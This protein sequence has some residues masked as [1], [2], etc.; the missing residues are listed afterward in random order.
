MAEVWRSSGR[1]LL[2]RTSAGLVVTDDFLRAFLLRPELAPVEESCAAERRLHERLFERPKDPV[3]SD[4]VARLAD[5]DACENWQA[6]LAFRSRLLAQPS[7]AAA[8]LDLV[9]RGM[10]GIPPLFLDQLVHV[11]VQDALDGARDPFR[12]R[13]AELL[14][15][16]QRVTIH[17]G[18]IMLA[19]EETVSM[20]SRTGG[21]GSLGRLLVDAEAPLRQIELDVLVPDNAQGYFARADRFDTVLDLGFTR[22]GLDALCRVLEA[23]VRH[24]LALGGRSQPV[25]EIRDERWVWHIGLDVEASRLL[26]AL[27][28]GETLDEDDRRRLLALFRLEIDDPDLM[29]ERVRAR[30]IYLALAMTSDGRLKLKPQNLLL[31][32]PLRAAG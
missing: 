8:Y 19:D 27:W 24:L 10:A 26:N 20:L 6:F 21:F 28:Q 11:L 15:R 13:A 9:G 23:W 3:A 22:Q 1:H 2:A 7:I 17:D 16:E 31:N 25:A 5:P 4:D 18:Q 29:L 12:F 30:P 32:L 14:F